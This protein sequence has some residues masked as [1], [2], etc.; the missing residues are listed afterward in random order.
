MPRILLLFA[1]H[2]GQTRLIAERIGD[3][4]RMHGHEVD[5]VDVRSAHLP[6]PEDYDAVVIGSRIEMGRHASGIRSYIKAHRADLARIPTAFFSVSMAAS[7]AG[8][9]ADPDGYLEAMFREVGWRPNQAIAFAGA[10]AY[11][12]YG[13]LTR[14]VLKMISRRTGQ[15]TDT[16]RDH[17]FTD[18]V[19]VDQ[20]AREV[21]AVAPAAAH[22]TGH[23]VPRSE[24][25][26]PIETATD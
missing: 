23:F 19:Q 1:S 3:R 17:E 21:A 4:L 8:A 15:T 20:F 18:W 14:W 2:Y 13:W 16:S 6:P 25:A 12:K 5:L 22:D 26:V 11:R 9:S 24:E 10:L 7:H